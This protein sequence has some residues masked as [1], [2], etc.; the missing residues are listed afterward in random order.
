[1]ER[2]NGGNTSA[3]YFALKKTLAMNMVLLYASHKCAYNFPIDYD[4]I[5]S[6]TNGRNGEL[7]YSSS[8]FVVCFVFHHRN[9]DKMCMTKK[10]KKL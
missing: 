10:W 6:F 8:M 9:I 1:M 7:Q 2:T 3:Q 4:L 5:F